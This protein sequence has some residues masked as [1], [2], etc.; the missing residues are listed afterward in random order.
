VADIREKDEE[1]FLQL[2]CHH[3]KEAGMMLLSPRLLVLPTET[4]GFL[5]VIDIGGRCEALLF[6]LERTSS[7][8]FSAAQRQ[9][10]QGNPSLSHLA[11]LL[12]MVCCSC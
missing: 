8:L 4:W 9:L 5:L 6:S 1:L 12:F 3:D 10:R 7:S 11:G 2:R